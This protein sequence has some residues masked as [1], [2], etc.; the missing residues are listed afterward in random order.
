M[1]GSQPAKWDPKRH[2]SRL[3][4]RS[5]AFHVG[6]LAGLCLLIGIYL[7][8]TTV[9]IARDGVFYIDQAQRLADNPISVAREHPP[10][11]PFLLWLAH[12]GAA[13]FAGQ[14]SHML[15]V[16]SAQAI[17]LLCRALALIPL[18]FLGKHLVGARDSFWAL[19][20]LIVLP[21]PAEYGSD[22]LREWP[23]VLFLAL[24]FWLL[25]WGLHNGRW[26][27]LALVGLNA[28]L[29][30]LIRPESAQLVFYALLGLL[31][32]GLATDRPLTPRPAIRTA[33]SKIMPVA[34]GL[35]LV[36]GFAIPVGPYVYATGTIVPQPLRPHLFNAP[37]VISAVGSKAATDEALEFE[38]CAGEL[39]ELHIDAFDPG[40]GPLTLSIAGT[41]VGTR[42]VYQFR[43]GASGTPFWTISRREKDSLLA[44]YRQE[45]R[46]YEGI[47]WYAY[48][49]PAARAGL[50][51]VHRFWSPT[52]RRHFY[53]ASPLEK[54]SIL[55]ESQDSWTY[56]GIAFYAFTEGDHCAD[57]V[58]VYRF[59]DDQRGYFWVTGEAQALAQDNAPP[60]V[61][62]WYVH[63]AGE[64][65]A[66]AALEG[67]A[68]QWRPGPDSP[69]EHQV[70]I[71]VDDGQL[72]SCQ[73]VRIRVVPRPAG[74]GACSCSQ[75]AGLSDFPKA[76]DK[77]FDAVTENLMVVF[78][79]PWLLGLYHRLRCKAEPLERTL[80]IALV[81]TSV[82]LMLVRHTWFGAQ[83]SRRYSLG[84]IVLT[85]FCIPTGL[86]LM[87][88]WLGRLGRS[89]G[90]HKVSADDGRSRGFYILVTI[91]I[92]ICIPKLLTPLHARKTGYRAAAV[93]LR[94]NTQADDVIAV[95]DSR[96]S[97]YADRQGLF[98]WEHP[99]SRKADYVVRIADKNQRQAPDD[100][101]QEYSVPVH[102]NASK[103][104]TIFK[105]AR[106]K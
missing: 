88:Q 32:C 104:L 70:N 17:T 82:A 69:G 46:A 53:T 71:I 35:L 34:A 6:V 58:P 16:Y 9:L 14:E 30:Y 89:Q 63:V 97:L 77:V 78:L 36:A 65:P 90:A 72:Q 39:L 95:P 18:Y 74:V 24:G 44:T 12:Q 3:R 83:T 85:I 37:P 98:Y 45:V 40:G 49:E 99:D 41:P 101:Q 102:S 66:G 103:T 92:G 100:G 15:W 67:R 64:P 21:Y 60:G 28:G 25:V 31:Y 51:G 54:E 56:E 87:A 13:S 73:L 62:A 20:I 86:A 2:A 68:L 75:Y 47:A 81:A 26:W 4:T 1:S 27:V 57:A 23:Y 91:G 106:P 7:I 76:V 48:G 22:V 29:G 33:Q 59:Y 10:G 42:P 84:L 105:T 5:D 79:A 80:M 50:Q 11:Y 52:Q 38:V 8:L 55:K 93:W 61:V 19:L 43:S 94:E 96:I